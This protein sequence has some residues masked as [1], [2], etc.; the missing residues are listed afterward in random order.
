MCLKIKKIKLILR[1]LTGT[2]LFVVAG[3]RIT[4]T[5]APLDVCLLVVCLLVVSCVDILGTVV[6]FDAFLVRVVVSRFASVHQ[7][8]I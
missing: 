2:S 7:A 5:V 4:E 3:W 8:I 6:I 1:G